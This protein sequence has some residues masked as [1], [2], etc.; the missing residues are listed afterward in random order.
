VAYVRIGAV[1]GVAV[2][3]AGV[4]LLAVLKAGA[5]LER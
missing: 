1:V 4:A 2:M 3:G 5:K